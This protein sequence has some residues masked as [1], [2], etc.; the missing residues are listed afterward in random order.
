LIKPTKGATLSTTYIEPF[1]Y[2]G[3]LPWKQKDVKKAKEAQD[4]L[5]VRQAFPGVAIP[6]P[7]IL[8][9]LP[10][11][12]DNDALIDQIAGQILT[13]PDLENPRTESTAVNGQSQVGQFITV[14]D[15]GM[16]PGDKDGGYKCYA[17][18]DV[19]QTGSDDHYV[20]NTGAPGILLFL[21]RVFLSGGLP[22][23]VVIETVKTGNNAHSDPLYM[24][25][26]K[27]FA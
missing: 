26:I 9:L 24:R 25:Q 7:R 18:L 23:D 6:I 19:T 5:M 20:V 8:H 2:A 4:Y 16:R 22:I 13:A 11:A 1:S 3:V 27:A 15:I 14:H 10:W 21:A 17:S 12:T